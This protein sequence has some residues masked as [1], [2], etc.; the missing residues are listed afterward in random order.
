MEKT[1]ISKALTSWCTCLL[2]DH[3]A[4]HSKANQPVETSLQLSGQGY[5]CLISDV[6]LL[7]PEMLYFCTTYIQRQA[8]LSPVLIKVSAHGQ[9]GFWWVPTWDAKQSRALFAFFSPLTISAQL[10]C[11]ENKAFLS[12]TNPADI[13]Q[14]NREK[15]HWLYSRTKYLKCH[16]QNNTKITNEACLQAVCP[17][18]YLMQKQLFYL[19]SNSF[20]AKCFSH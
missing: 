18:L 19:S 11:I 14:S 1:H 6:F 7:R 5:Y 13:N 20:T 2:Y 15:S 3:R 16:G 4:H 17:P 10:T 12:V 9:N 8:M